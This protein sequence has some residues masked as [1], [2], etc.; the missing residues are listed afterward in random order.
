MPVLSELSDQLSG[1]CA[2]L[3]IV[4]FGLLCGWLMSDA[5]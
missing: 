1:W 4:C 3:A 5:D 2:L